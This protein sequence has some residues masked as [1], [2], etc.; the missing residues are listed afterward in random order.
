MKTFGIKLT[1]NTETVMVHVRNLR[2]IE[3]TPINPQYLKVV[4]GVEFYKIEKQ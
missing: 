1:I 3:I 2:K 4:L